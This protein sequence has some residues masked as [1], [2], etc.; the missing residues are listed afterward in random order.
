MQILPMGNI[1]TTSQL[2]LFRTQKDLVIGNYII[3]EVLIKELLARCGGIA[4]RASSRELASDERRDVQCL[5]IKRVIPLSV[6]LL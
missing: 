2:I 3:V 1:N 6:L 4:H 5:H